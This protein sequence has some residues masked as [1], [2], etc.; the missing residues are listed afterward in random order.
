[1]FWFISKK[2]DLERCLRWIEQEEFLSYIDLSYIKNMFNV[3]VNGWLDGYGWI[4]HWFKF[5]SVSSV[6][7]YIKIYYVLCTKRLQ[8]TDSFKITP[9]AI[10]IIKKIYS[11]IYS[12]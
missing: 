5:F 4:G 8:I 9:F 6:Q 7:S 3:H 10:E 12:Q 2:K 1:M 11:K